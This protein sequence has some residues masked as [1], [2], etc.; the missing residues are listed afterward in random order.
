MNIITNI[1]R[2]FI[3]TVERRQYIQ[4]FKFKSTK[5]NLLFCLICL[6][7][8]MV[9]SALWLLD[10]LSIKLPAKGQLKWCVL[11]SSVVE[12]KYVLSRH[13]RATKRYLLFDEILKLRPCFIPEVACSVFSVGVLPVSSLLC[14]VFFTA[15][16][17]E[18]IVRAAW[19]VGDSK[20]N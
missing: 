17:L 6:L 15:W 13:I 2:Y 19:L 7:D 4:F 16:E 8:K 1:R 12:I 9:D 11:T 10:R 5:V 3:S 14:D 20:S 18:C